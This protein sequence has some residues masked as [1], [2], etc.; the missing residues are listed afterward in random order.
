MTCLRLV[1]PKDRNLCF[2][3]TIVLLPEH[4]SA[5]TL[6]QLCPSLGNLTILA[7]QEYLLGVQFS[8]FLIIVNVC[9]GFI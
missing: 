9:S 6:A 1:S 5:L 4:F 3:G 8:Y 7:K 2:G